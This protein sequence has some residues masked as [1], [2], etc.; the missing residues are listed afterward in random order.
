M[1]ATFDSN[2]TVTVT[3]D[4]APIGRAGFGTP[5]VVDA[6]SMA[7]RIRFYTSAAAAAADVTAGEITAAQGTAIALAFSQRVRPRRVAAGRVAA[8][9][10][11]V[12]TLT[13]GGTAVTGTYSFLVNGDLVEFAATVPTDTNSDIGAGLRADATTVLAGSGIV[14][15][16]A[17]T[18]II[19]TGVAGEPFA[20]TALTAPGTGTL[21][22]ITTDA[23][24]IGGELDAI[25]A[26]N[27]DWYGLTLVSRTKLTI[28][29]AAA[30][31]ETQPRIFIAQSSDADILTTA[32]TDI[33]YELEQLA[34][35]RTAVLYYPTN[36][37]YADL[38]WLA[39]RL[40][41]DLDVQQT[42]WYSV[43]LVGV[44]P[45]SSLSETQKTNVLNKNA[46]L[47]L[48]QG[49]LGST[50]NGLMASGQDIDEITTIDWVVARIREAITQLFLTESN[51]LRKVP[52]TEEGFSQIA[53]VVNPVLQRGVAAEHFALS[54]SG[55]G[56]FV[57]MPTL[58]EVDPADRAARLLRFTFYALLAGAIR[59][60]SESGAD[61]SSNATFECFVASVEEV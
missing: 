40:A 54:A 13:V 53:S 17:T 28:L 20:V 18:S 4:G 14:V 52:F 43:T 31:T 57:D 19:L 26:E 41:A 59:S 50:G 47:Y 58:A 11:Q 38:A 60:V 46:N 39:N 36:G 24:T 12:T 44:T 8:E 42:V 6:A 15:T 34:Y 27:G 56:P 49:G 1:G 25:V 61:T 55:D 2:V 10:S 37:T 32:N 16:G 51:A 22:Q 29:H 23:V 9:T 33:A 5:L 21:T 30:W 48:T 3:T 45:T 7:E 35:Q